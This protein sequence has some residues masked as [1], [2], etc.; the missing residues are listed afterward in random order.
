MIDQKRQDASV[1]SSNLQSNPRQIYSPQ[2]RLFKSHPRLFRPPLLEFVICVFRIYNILVASHGLPTAIIDV[3]LQFSGNHGWDTLLQPDISVQSVVS[4]LVE[5][6]LPATSKSRIG[7]PI[8]IE[9]RRRIET[10]VSVVEVKYAALADIEEE[11]C[12]DATPVSS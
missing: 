7:L 11:P 6:E 3:R 10:T 8:P 4:L 2:F 5:E 9:V 1:T 12:I